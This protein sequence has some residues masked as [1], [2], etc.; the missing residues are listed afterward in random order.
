MHSLMLNISEF[1]NYF[2][3]KKELLKIDMKINQFLWNMLIIWSIH[4]PNSWMI[5]AT[6]SIFD[7]FIRQVYV[8]KCL[9]FRQ[10]RDPLSILRQLFLTEGKTS[11]IP[12][13]ISMSKDFPLSRT[14]LAQQR[15]IIVVISAHLIIACVGIS[16]IEAISYLWKYESGSRCWLQDL[17][18]EGKDWRGCGKVF[19]EL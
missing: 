19:F 7:F 3:F 16:F 6:N 11:F 8:L 5:S 9:N 2:L 4:I 13:S 15:Q 10:L 17:W 1:I 18:G 14:L 12:R